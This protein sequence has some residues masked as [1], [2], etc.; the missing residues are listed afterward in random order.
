MILAE[1]VGR[2]AYIAIHMMTNRRHGSLYLSVTGKLIQ[3]IG[4]HRQGLIPGFTKTHGLKR[5][6]WFKPHESMTLAI[7]REKLLKK[8]KREWNINLIERDNPNWDD[9][10]S[11]LIG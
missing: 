9:L 8:Y 3:R 11:A 4:Q 7:H 2:E 1:M 6:V 5:V 10:Y